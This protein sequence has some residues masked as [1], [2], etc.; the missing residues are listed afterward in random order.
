MIVKIEELIRT[1][2]NK[3]VKITHTGN[4]SLRDGSGTC[5]TF[6]TTESGVDIELEDKS[7]WGLI[8]DQLTN[9]SVEGNVDALIAG[10]R[11]IQII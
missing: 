3:Q 2:A 6:H 7:R 4:V 1:F 10:R 5:K 8:P 11:K 9:D